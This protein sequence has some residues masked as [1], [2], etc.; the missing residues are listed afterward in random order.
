MWWGLFYV[1]FYYSTRKKLPRLF[2]CVLNILVI[3][4]ILG[5]FTPEKSACR[6]DKKFLLRLD[7]PSSATWYPL[8]CDLI[9]PFSHKLPTKKRTFLYDYIKKNNSLKKYIKYDWYN[10]RYFAL[11]IA[12]LF[13]DLLDFWCI[14]TPKKMYLV[15]M[16]FWRV[17]GFSLFGF[18][19]THAKN[20][21]V[22]L[23][24]TEYTGYSSYSGNFHP[25]KVRL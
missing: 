14:H 1:R 16:S 11:K 6:A 7:T 2:A 4:V 12:I 15:F 18:I 23:R 10:S 3:L 8:L 19:T 25:R 13:D 9:P 24:V 20:L 5:I 22:F 21:H 17:G